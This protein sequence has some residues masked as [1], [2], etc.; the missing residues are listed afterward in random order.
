M[1]AGGGSVTGENKRG[2]CYE[3]ERSCCRELL[4]GVGITTGSCW[5]V[6]LVSTRRTWGVTIAS[7]SG[8]VPA[9]LIDDMDVF[10]V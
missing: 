4:A 9:L 5:E 7:S 2:S 8:R 3:E 1:S 6:E 10:C